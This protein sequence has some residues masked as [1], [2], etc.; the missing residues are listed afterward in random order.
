MNVV[1]VH[2]TWLDAIGDV[3][4][5]LYVR[6]IPEQGEYVSLFAGPAT[7]N[8]PFIEVE[9]ITKPETEGKI[10]IPAKIPVGQVAGV[11]DLTEAEARKYGFVPPT[12]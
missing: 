7:V 10:S 6:T 8:F 2:K 1:F 5:L 4:K 11:F 12:T 3:G 9:L